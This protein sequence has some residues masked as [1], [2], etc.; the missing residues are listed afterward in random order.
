MTKNF[1]LKIYK[2]LHKKTKHNTS[3]TQGHKR[4]HTNKK[5]HKS[6]IQTVKSCKDKQKHAQ[7]IYPHNVFL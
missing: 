5:I 7:N 6:N 2:T 4:K 3:Q 1:L